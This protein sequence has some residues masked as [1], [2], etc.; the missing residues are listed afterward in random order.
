MRPRGLQHERL[1]L[2]WIGVYCGVA[3]LGVRLLHLQVIRNVYYSRVAESQRT[4]I[5]P[6]SA[7]RGRIY[8]RHGELVAT[9]RPAFSLIYLPVENKSAARL[10]VL[11]ESLAKELRQTKEEILDIL[12]EAQ[13]ENSAVRLAENLPLEARFKFG[14]LKTLYPGVDLIVEARRH[15]PR[16]EFASH[17]LGYMSKMDKRS[18]RKLKGRGYRVDSWIGKAGIEQLYEDRLRGTDGE[19]RMEVDAQGRLKRRIGESHWQ[20]GSHIHLTIDARIQA[21]IEEGLRKSPSGKGG[22]V[23]MDPR[24]GEVLALA[25]IPEFDPNLFLLPEWD[26]AKKALK[27]FPAFNRAISGTYPPAS[28]F[29]IVS[30][31]AFVENG[32]DPKHKI[33]CPGAFRVGKR[34]FRCW[35]RTG[36]KLQ[37]FIGGITHSCDVYFYKKVLQVGGAAVEAYAKKFG[38]GRR[39]GIALPNE[40]SGNMFGPEARRKRSRS[41]YDGDSVNQSIGQ[42]EFLTTP[43]QM[44][45]AVSAVANRGT[46]W[47]PHFTQ[48]I[49]E[50]NGQVVYEA[51]P[52]PTGKVDLKPETWDLLQESLLSVIKNGTG[53][54]L[55]WGVGDI[56]VSGKTGTGENPHGDD[57]AWFV[58]YAGRPDEEPSLAVSVL[59]EN[60]GHGSSAAG[61]I[62]KKVIQTAFDIKLA[63]LPK[64]K[65]APVEKPVAPVVPV[66][67]EITPLPVVG[68]SG[69][70]PTVKPITQPGVAQ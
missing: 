56:V 43:L 24:N 32:V 48:R 64:K 50:P 51:Q 47:K 41:W 38:L 23:V 29:K 12:K 34:R 1:T 39:T 69:A 60:G 33:F 3:I 65:K 25:S 10:G 44:A 16:G 58:A 67:P 9:N 70:G 31:S 57:H 17:L 14:E 35:V 53:R 20:Q 55:A 46:L 37:D 42:G 26:E 5:I 13:K 30:G 7:P 2:L 52:T 68:T 27:S 4:E 45:V 63:H 54:R 40:R 66:R 21:V 22:V 59:V 61:P 36:H 18:W 6:Q 49:I 19:I 8:D 28:T 11:A 62:A 15:Y